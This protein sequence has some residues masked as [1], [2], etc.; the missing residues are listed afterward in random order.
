VKAAFSCKKSGLAAELTSIYP[1]LQ[2]N[3]KIAAGPLKHEGVYYQKD[4][5]A[6]PKEIRITKKGTCYFNSRED[7]RPLGGEK[8]KNIIQSHY[9]HQWRRRSREKLFC[10]TKNPCALTCATFADGKQLTILTFIAKNKSTEGDLR[11][12]TYY[13]CLSSVT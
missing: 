1:Q 8:C 3:A 10:S 9:N 2:S 7:R 13:C 6:I 12:S 4:P 5:A 11:M